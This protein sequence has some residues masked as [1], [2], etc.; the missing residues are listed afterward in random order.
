[1]SR[2]T[3]RR[4]TSIAG[5]LPIGVV[6]DLIGIEPQDRAAVDTWIANLR[7]KLT[8]AQWDDRE[9]CRRRRIGASE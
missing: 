8:R 9:A 1:M 4:D 6:R 5:A 3:D 2:A 7:G